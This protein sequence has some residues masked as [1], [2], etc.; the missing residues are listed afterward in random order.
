[1]AVLMRMEFPGRTTGQYDEVNR[2][3][4][5]DDDSPPEGLIL[6][7][8][9]KTDDGILVMDVWESAEDAAAF[10]ES[11][12]GAALEQVEAPLEPASDA[13]GAQH[14][15][16]RRRRRRQ[17]DPGDRGRRRLRTSTTTWSGRCRATRATTRTHPVHAHIA[18]VTED[19]KMYIVDLWGV[20]GG[21]PG[22]RGIRRSRPRPTAGWARSRRSS[23]RCT[24][25]SAARPTLPRRSQASDAAGAPLR[26]T[27]PTGR[28]SRSRIHLDRVGALVAQDRAAAGSSEAGRGP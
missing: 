11:G 5:I 20:T 24:T 14:D 16:A 15:P 28:P 19:G 2:I 25:S 21:L 22:V 23:H 3:L 13:Q 26:G 9:G 17:R 10:F 12:L 7:M 4:G 6:H 8:C 27:G 1:M 18:A